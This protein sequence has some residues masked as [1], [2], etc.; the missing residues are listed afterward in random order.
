M[1]PN[2][3]TCLQIETNRQPAVGG[4]PGPGG[5]RE[6]ERWPPSA[7]LIN[8]Y[9]DV[10]PEPPLQSA[11]KSRPICLQKPNFSLFIPP[12][13]PAI[14]N[15]VSTTEGRWSG[16]G[17]GVWGRGRSSRGGLSSGTVC[18]WNPSSPPA[19]TPPPLYCDW[20]S[21]CDILKA[22]L[23]RHTSRR[24]NNEPGGL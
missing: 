9:S 10:K 24:N 4:P 1:A 2:R 3:C 20:L 5:Q 19:P 6:N 13:R 18:W 16:G 22:A 12:D 7:P 11:F 15:I 14:I 17:E 8:S 21:Q 23:Y